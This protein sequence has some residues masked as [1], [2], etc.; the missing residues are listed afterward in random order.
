MFN[1]SLEQD[2]AHAT[3]QERATEVHP[4]K[5]RKTIQHFKDCGWVNLESTRTVKHEL[6]QQNTGEGPAAHQEALIMSIVRNSHRPPKRR[7]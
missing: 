4:V 7:P 6:P 1:D 2:D 5:T 3:L